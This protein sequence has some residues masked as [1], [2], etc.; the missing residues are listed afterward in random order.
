MSALQKVNSEMMNSTSVIFHARPVYDGTLGISGTTNKVISP[1]H[2]DI[3]QGGAF[4]GST[5]IFLAPFDGY[6]R[7]D[8]HCDIQT[9]NGCWIEFHRND[10]ETQSRIY[11]YDTNNWWINVA[12]HKVIQLNTG[13]T[14][15]LVLQVG[16]SSAQLDGNNYGGYSGCLL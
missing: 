12:G 3:N 14:F 8:F 5:G 4:D 15:K 11:H 6:Y 16:N 2:V 1:W 9:T 10:V 13:D 7:F